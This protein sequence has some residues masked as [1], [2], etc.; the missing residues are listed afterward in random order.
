[1]VTLMTKYTHAVVHRI[2]NEKNK[3]AD[4]LTYATDINH[5]YAI[6]HQLMAAGKID[7]AIIQ[8]KEPTIIEDRPNE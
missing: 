2:L 1:M 5:A 6:A 8:L 7:L 4:E 3:E